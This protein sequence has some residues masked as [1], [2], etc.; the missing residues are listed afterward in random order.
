[1]GK[2]F[3]RNSSMDDFDNFEDPWGDGNKKGSYESIFINPF[4]PGPEPVAEIPVTY[5]IEDQRLADPRPLDRIENKKFFSSDI[6]TPMEEEVSQPFYQRQHSF[7]DALI[8]TSVPID[9]LNDPLQMNFESVA[10][11]RQPP[12]EALVEETRSYIKEG[13]RVGQGLSGYIEYPIFTQTSNKIY[14][15]YQFTTIRRYSDFLYLYNQLTNKYPGLII[16]PIPEKSTIQKFQPE[17][18]EN[19]KICLQ[20][21]LDYLNLHKVFGGCVDLKEFLESETFNEDKVE[22]RAPSLLGTFNFYL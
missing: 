19:R 3:F 5:T 21:F 10:E 6:I 2:F 22:K 13:V 20:M 9:E 14:R 12:K 17:F 8:P 16:P 1:M 11:E 4:A 15:N 7:K 18:I